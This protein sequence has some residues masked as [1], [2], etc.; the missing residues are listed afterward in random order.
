MDTTANSKRPLR[1]RIDEIQVNTGGDTGG[2]DSYELA[3]LGDDFALFRK[4]A[5][6][7]EDP[8]R[9]NGPRV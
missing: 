3:A 4:V 8:A 2:K 6:P 5:A 7:V 1:V 9:V